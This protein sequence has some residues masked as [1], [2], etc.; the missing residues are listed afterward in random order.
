MLTS[1]QTLRIVPACSIANCL[2]TAGSAHHQRLLPLSHSGLYLPYALHQKL[3]LHTAYHRCSGGCG[4]PPAP[5]A[6]AAGAGCVCPSKIALKALCSD[7]CS[8]RTC[9]N[10]A[11]VR[12]AQGHTVR[13]HRTQQQLVSGMPV[14]NMHMHKHTHEPKR[15]SCAVQQGAAIT[16]LARTAGTCS[17]IPAHQL[18]N[19]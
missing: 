17:S 16:R 12:T 6:A 3:L 1:V 14:N 9:S 8:A 10:A 13:S 19:T 2:G 7:L 11:H 5:A 15:E 18:I 4:L